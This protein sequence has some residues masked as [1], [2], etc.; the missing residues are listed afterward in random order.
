MWN[1]LKRRDSLPS[2]VIPSNL[3]TI[4]RVPRFFLGLSE[5]DRAGVLGPLL[6]PELIL[7]RFLGSCPGCLVTPHSLHLLEVSASISAPQAPSNS[8][9]VTF[10]DVGQKV[11]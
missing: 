2:P 6:V 5:W 8:V 11:D 3:L 7:L 1:H 10:S 4:A 9:L